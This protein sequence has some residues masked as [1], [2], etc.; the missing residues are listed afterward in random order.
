MYVN[1]SKYIPYIDPMV[2]NGGRD[3]CNAP[4]WLIPPD[5]EDSTLFPGDHEI[6]E[7]GDL[8]VRDCDLP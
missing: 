2:T 1:Y 6:Y 5:H 3:S 8:R 4:K 7:E